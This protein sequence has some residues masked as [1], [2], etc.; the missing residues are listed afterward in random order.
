MPGPE[1][2]PD[3]MP[4]P[5]GAPDTAAWIEALGH[6]ARHFKVPFSPRGAERLA[7]ALEAASEGEAVARLGRRHG[8]RVRPVPASPSA[9]TS[10]RLPVILALHDGSVGVVTALGAGG[11]ASV[12]FSGD[13]GLA[14]TLPCDILLAE[15]RLMV[16]ARPERAAAD[17]RVDA[18]IAPYREHWFRRLALKDIRPYGHV[19][20]ASLVANTLALA[21][22]LFS[23]QVYDRVVPA[24]SLNTL[25]VLFI[26]V[27][28]AL[29]FDFVMRRARTRIIDILG[30]R[31]DMRISDLVFGHALRVKNGARP[32][33]TG[34]FIAQLRD[35]EQVRE[36]LTSTTVAAIA[37]LPFFF[38][39]LFIFWQIGG[40][41]A[42]VPAAA[43]VLLVVPGLAVQGRLRA[44]AN[45]A[46]RESSL[47]NAM[48]VE[49]VQGVEDIKS[50]QAEDHF[51]E[52]WNHFNAVAGEAQLRL[53]AI[54]NGLAAWSQCVQTGTFAV[55]VF[56]GAPLVMA[57]D[58]TTGALV[59][60]SIL[61]SRMMAPMSQITQVLG[62][63]QQAKVGLKSLDSIMQLPVDHPETETRV[64]APLLGGNYRLRAAAFHYA[65][66]QRPALTVGDLAIA[67]GERIALL[68]KNG[69]GKSTLLM[70][71][72]GLAEPASGEV[73][74]DDLAL[75]QI[76]PADL[77]RHVGLLAQGAR[78]FHGTIRENVTMG[79]LHASQPALLDALAMVG[80]DE[81]IRRLPKGLDHPIL[82]GG[83]G[84]SGGQQQALLLARLLIRDPSIVLLDEPTAAMDEAS[85]RHFLSRFQ[86]WSEGRTVV[87]ATHRMRVLDLVRRVLVVDGGRIVL[88]EP[89]EE[90]LKRMRGV[91]KVMGAPAVKDARPALR[92]VAQGGA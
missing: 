54:T 64:S 13:D 35:L 47:R 1:L 39:F 7:G 73:L 75:N 53:R 70:A 10:R 31:T 58:M 4:Q 86:A 20:L 68:G 6:V 59:A 46:M 32:N 51:Q 79:A 77:R 82:E 43:L 71:L 42:A 14:T 67:Q 60:S 23:M 22:V 66:S 56:F 29:F 5:E 88:D 61:S 8:L 76:D 89:K 28:I 37:D 17:E 78:L 55:I 50:L 18:Y 45:E 34:T 85:E 33:S 36:L 57:G 24:R 15:T 48:L 40:P 12:V 63:L 80:A 90:A 52:R 38:L 84:L 87:I 9:L 83:R 27:L 30:K 25:H 3:R 26:G 2:K 65:E 81:F 69:A 92:A 72:A 11:E 49:A 44:C 16:M 19:L 74:V 62:R 41:L 21:G 91:G